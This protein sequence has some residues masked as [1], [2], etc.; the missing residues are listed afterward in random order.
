[1]KTK[2]QP[3]G[4]NIQKNGIYTDYIITALT[5]LLKGAF[6]RAV[7]FYLFDELIRLSIASRIA[8]A[9]LGPREF[10]SS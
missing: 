8:P 5:N 7:K 1:M 4:R 6:V 9:A 3:N 10:V 2:K